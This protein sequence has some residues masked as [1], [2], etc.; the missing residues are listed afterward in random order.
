M[1]S[2]TPLDPQR[3]DESVAGGFVTA[4]ER[5]RPDVTRPPAAT[6]TSPS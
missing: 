2:Q 5:S 1:R 3:W 4:A 6:I